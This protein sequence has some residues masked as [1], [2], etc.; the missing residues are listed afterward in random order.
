[1]K[2]TSTIRPVPFIPGD[3]IGPKIMDGAALGAQ[4]FADSIISYMEK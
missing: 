3:G 2:T 4:E 1:M